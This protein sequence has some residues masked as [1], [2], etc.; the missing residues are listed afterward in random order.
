[1]IT[2]TQLQ[3]RFPGDFDDYSDEFIEL[4][5]AEA[6]GQISE[7]VWGSDY[8]LG[9]LYLTAHI[10]QTTTP[11]EGAAD[12]GPINHRKIG[13]VEVRSAAYLATKSVDGMHRTTYGQAFLRLRR[14]HQG[15]PLV[16]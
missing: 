4:I 9:L 6:A 13:D 8:D 3:T 15:G 1:M 12:A 2:P 16:V 14:I 7:T 11:E 10:I 5:I